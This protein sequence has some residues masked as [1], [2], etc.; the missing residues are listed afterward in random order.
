MSKST[1]GK[2]PNRATKAATDSMLR[3]QKGYQPP[4]GP[5]VIRGY[6]GTQTGQPVDLGNPPTSGS[7]VT[8]VSQPTAD[9]D[10]GQ[11]GATQPTS[12]QSS[13]E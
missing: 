3:A 12:Q 13:K 2:S 8:P 11:P 10:Q 6:Q 5:D 4:Q 9:S 1:S 7:A